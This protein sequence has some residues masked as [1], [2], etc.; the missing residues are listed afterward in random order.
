MN[1]HLYEQAIIHKNQHIIKTWWFCLILNSIDIRNFDHF[2]FFVSCTE[3]AD[4]PLIKRIFRWIQDKEN[5]LVFF[6]ENPIIMNEILNSMDLEFMEHVFTKCPLEHIYLI[7]IGQRFMRARAIEPN[8]LSLVVEISR[9]KFPSEIPI[10]RVYRQITTENFIRC[11]MI[12]RDHVLRTALRERND[13]LVYSVI[14]NFKNYVRY[15][16]S[17]NIRNDYEIRKYMIYESLHESDEDAVKRFILGV[18]V[19]KSKIKRRMDD[20][21]EDEDYEHQ[22]RRTG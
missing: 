7:P 4:I 20:D 12:R 11:E 16:A 14:S 3:Q 8:I 9:K 2:R 13:P 1:H 22:R 17:S 5:Y 21:D 15:C 18:E 10:L 19:T 6:L